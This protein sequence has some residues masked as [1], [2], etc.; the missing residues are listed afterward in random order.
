MYLEEADAIGAILPFRVRATDEALTHRGLQ[1][2][3]FFDHVAL[4]DR[5]PVRSYVIS[6]ERIVN[7]DFNAAHSGRA[8]RRGY[9]STAQFFQVIEACLRAQDERK[10]VYAYFPELDSTAHERGIGSQQAADVLRRFDEG[11]ARLLS[12]IAGYDVTV[13]V[14]AD[15]GFVDA[16]EA[17]RIELDQHPFLAE[18][19]A[20]PLCGEQR[21][22]Y[23]YVQ[24]DKAATFEAYVRHELGDRITLV[25]SRSAIEAGWFG[26]GEPHP[27]LASR[28]GDYILLLT[29]C[30][31]IK[32]WMPGEKRYTLV[33]VH[34]GVSEHEM[35]VPLI[36]V[37]P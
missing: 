4:Y 24:P 13:I 30:G 8:E 14:C 17:E 6:P 27:R 20:R 33:G 28:I 35:Q 2:T 25:D 22:A 19:L 7:S 12:A 1:P 23:C 34:G 21:V 29:G 37:T 16:P 9:G 3:S 26:P 36:V 15:H 11:F 31:T 18:C 5:L 32:D 10:L